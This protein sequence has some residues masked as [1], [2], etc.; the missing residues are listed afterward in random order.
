MKMVD[1][2]AQQRW[3]AEND[4]RVL[5]EAREIRMDKARLKAA[6]ALAIELRAALEHIVGDEG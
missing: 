2:Q 3:Q 4:L 6:K 1:Q 5:K